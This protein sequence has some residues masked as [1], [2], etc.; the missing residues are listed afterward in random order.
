MYM[1][2][3]RFLANDQIYLWLSRF[4]LP[5][6]FSC[7]LDIYASFSPILYY[8]KCVGHALKVL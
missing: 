4:W 1:T 6:N 3:P 8:G 2:L 7:T 5:M